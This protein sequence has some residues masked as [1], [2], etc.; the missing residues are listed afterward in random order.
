[1]KKFPTIWQFYS[2]RR[3]D[4]EQQRVG[5]R[6]LG[7]DLKR[8]RSILNTSS[9]SQYFLSGPTSQILPLWSYFP[10]EFGVV[11]NLTTST[12][13]ESQLDCL[14][15]PQ[16]SGHRPRP[17][18]AVGHQLC[19]GPQRAPHYEHDHRLSSGDIKFI[20]F[21]GLHQRSYCLIVCNKDH[22]VR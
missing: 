2:W 7:S 18:D 5:R 10:N 12:I 15:R 1:M 13:S 19:D 8:S 3:S 4:W 20:L 14:S 9:L 11:H 21:D 22:I 16:L 17:A 6:P